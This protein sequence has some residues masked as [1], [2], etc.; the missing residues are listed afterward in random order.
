MFNATVLVAAVSQQA[1]CYFKFPNRP[2]LYTHNQSYGSLLVHEFSVY[3]VG[4][5]AA[6]SFG[7]SD[8]F[9]LCMNAL[10]SL[11]NSCT[12]R[13]LKCLIYILQ[14]TQSGYTYGG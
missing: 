13:G 5:K 12:Y 6:S 4:P 3:V 7:L 14:H 10:E 2:Q 9:L 1:G 8:W 11:W